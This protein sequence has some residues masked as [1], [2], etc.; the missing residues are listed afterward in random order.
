MT[1]IFFVAF[2]ILAEFNEPYNS[3]DSSCLLT[4]KMEV[5]SLLNHL[6]DWSKKG[7][8]NDL[9]TVIKLISDLELISKA[10]KEVQNEILRLIHEILVEANKDDENLKD[11]FFKEI[12]DK[13]KRLESFFG[14][15]SFYIILLKIK[16]MSFKSTASIDG[17]SYKEF[18]IVKTS[19]IKNFGLESVLTSELYVVLCMTN[20]RIKKWSELKKNSEISLDVKTKL[21]IDGHRIIKTVSY[22]IKSDVMLGNY[23]GAIKN[24]DRLESYLLEETD[25]FYLR[26]QLRIF[27]SLATAYAKL[28]KLTNA[29]SMQEMAVAAACELFN[30]DSPQAKEQ[31]QVLR[32][33]LAKNREFT[34]LRNLEDR[35]KLQPLPLQKGEK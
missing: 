23:S 2:Q 16:I 28:D 32:D 13:V 3:L 10:N 18:E 20:N 8:K 4:N 19:C 21:G 6:I 25:D 7:Q 35:F 24:K 14:Q 26:P 1:I 11:S 27:S 12:N 30:S 34:S 15:D 5:D 9:K 17:I 29:I 22:L 31:A 33:L